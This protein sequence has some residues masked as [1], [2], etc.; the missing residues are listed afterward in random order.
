MAKTS[1]DAAVMDRP[2]PIQHSY[3][4]KIHLINERSYFDPNT[5]A[6]KPRN[7]DYLALPLA[8]PEDETD[9]TKEPAIRRF[10]DDRIYNPKSG[11][12]GVSVERQMTVEDVNTQFSYGWATQRDVRKPRWNGWAIVT[13]SNALGKNILPREFSAIGIVERGECMLVGCLRDLREAE[14]KGPIEER[15]QIMK[16]YLPRKDGGTGNFGGT[17]AVAIGDAVSAA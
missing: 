13:K 5:A 1:D 8:T 15:A 9:N 10:V 12:F 4:E 7:T 17:G 14:I 11:K 2:S 6:R 16:N 3:D